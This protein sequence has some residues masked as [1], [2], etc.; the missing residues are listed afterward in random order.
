MHRRTQIKQTARM[1][2]RERDDGGN[3][4]PVGVG[5]KGLRADAGRVAQ[6]V[7]EGGELFFW[8]VLGC[9]GVVM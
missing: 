3:A 5:R 2:A 7:V 8:G 9:M 1:Y 4:E 6:A